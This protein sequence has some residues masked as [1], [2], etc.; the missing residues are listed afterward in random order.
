[1]VI[2][3]DS[4]DKKYHLVVDDWKI[5]EPDPRLFD[6]KYQGDDDIAE[7]IAEKNAKPLPLEQIF[8][9]D[10]PHVQSKVVNLT[11]LFADYNTVGDNRPAFGDRD[12]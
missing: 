6:P 3:K 10:P 1:M 4:G 2:K 11:N 12:R 8:A 5:K 7:K 9:S